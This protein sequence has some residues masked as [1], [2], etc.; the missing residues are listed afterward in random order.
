LLKTS[1]SLEG[2]HVEKKGQY[3]YARGKRWQ[4]DNDMVIDE[5]GDM[6][7]SWMMLP[8]ETEITVMAQQI[9]NEKGS[10]TFRN[11]NPNKKNR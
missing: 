11:W 7:I 9:K 1:I 8:S 10:T 3:Y 4:I 5:V 6:R 2:Y